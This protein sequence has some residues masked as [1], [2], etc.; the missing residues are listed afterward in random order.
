[1][2][3]PGG[4]DFLPVPCLLPFSLPPLASGLQ[5]QPAG[6]MLTSSNA[7]STQVGEE[8]FDLRNIETQL[9]GKFNQENVHNQLSHCHI[10][11]H[12]DLMRAPVGGPAEMISFFS[13][14]LWEGGR[15]AEEVSWVLGKLAI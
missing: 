3:A 12:G 14:A 13:K 4:V 11:L 8:R 15:G 9:R 2:H 1:M 7:V 6:K 5:Q 10:T